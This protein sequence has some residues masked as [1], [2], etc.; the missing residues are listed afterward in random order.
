MVKIGDAVILVDEHG[1]EHKAL[2]TNTWGTSGQE[3][4]GVNTVFVSSDESKTDPYGR[5]VDRKTS[6]VH[7][8]NQSAPGMYWK[9]L[10]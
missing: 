4:P 8:T 1:V 7:Q 3:F 10:T 9:E 6:V 5:Q 2:V